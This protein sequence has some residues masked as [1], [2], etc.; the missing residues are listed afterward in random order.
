[1]SCEQNNKCIRIALVDDQELVRNGIAELLSMDDCLEV[2]ITAA[3][4]LELIES[5]AGAPV[6]VIVMDVRMP[7]ESGIETVRKLRESGDRTPVLI[8]TTFDE[9][10]LL[11]QST[12]AGAQGFMLKDTSQEELVG[13][14][15]TLSEGGTA[16]QPIPVKGIRVRHDYS[17]TPQVEDLTDRELDVLRLM[18]GGYTNRD[19]AGVLHLA[20]GTVKNYVSEIL[21]KLGVRDRTKAVLTAITNH[22]L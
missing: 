8:L 11:L 16:L 9:P 14:I 21:I 1:M 20:E 19:I 22:I 4:G 18:A 6:D 2:A 17:A 13:A 12:E 5:L 3:N 10:N 7:G 15:R